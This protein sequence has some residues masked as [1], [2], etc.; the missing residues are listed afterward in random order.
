MKISLEEERR[1]LLEKIEASRHVYRRMLSGEAADTFIAPA[2]GLAAKQPARS[3]RQQIGEWVSD[4]PLQIAAG[5][6]VLVWLGP[7]LIRRIHFRRKARIKAFA[8]SPR[9]GTA[10]AIAAVLLLLLRDP[11]RLQTTASVLTT[12]WQWLRSR[13]FNSTLTSRRKP[14][15]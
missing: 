5:V 13:A 9:A 2:H 8:S 10:K 6:A 11:R 14:Y 3:T 4:H 7:G 12:A 15:A 1:T